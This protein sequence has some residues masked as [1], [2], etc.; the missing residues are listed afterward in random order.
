MNLDRKGFSYGIFPK[1]PLP[2]DQSAATAA[3]V[4]YNLMN[5]TISE[6]LRPKIGERP[7][8]LPSRSYRSIRRVEKTHEVIWDLYY[9]MDSFGRRII[10]GEDKK[11]TARQFLL[12]LGDS[13][14][15]G[16]GVR[17]DQTL[18]AFLGARL[19]DYRVYNYGIPGLFPGEILDALRSAH[20]PGAIPQKAGVALYFYANWHIFRNMGSSFPVGHWG[21]GRPDY[22]KNSNGKFV[23]KGTFTETR[24]IWTQVARWMSKSNFIRFFGINWPSTP[25]DADWRLYIELLLQI[26]EESK[27]LGANEFWVI[28]YPSEANETAA[29]LIPYLERAKI[30]YVDFSQWDYTLLMKGPTRI[31]YDGHPTP[32]THGFVANA[33]LNSLN[34]GL[35]SR[36]REND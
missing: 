13:Y 24:P 10:P 16:E 9:G 25:T 4:P 35:L 7:S 2:I 19:P 33:V 27:S 18:G 1:P 6:Q 8:N 26:Q 32:L 11:N 12:L 36:S 21:Y 22:T 31:K 17:D 5:E 30:H 3:E 29:E 28:L 20:A 14:V 15:F 23:A 34:L